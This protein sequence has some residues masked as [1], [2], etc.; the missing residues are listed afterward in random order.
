MRNSAAKQSLRNS[1]HC[2]ARKRIRKVHLI[3]CPVLWNSTAGL[4]STSTTSWG[5]RILKVFQEFKI[6]ENIGFFILDNASSN[7]TCVDLVLY[8]LYLEMSAKQHLRRRLRYLGHV[9]NLS[10][11]VFLLGQQSQETLGQLEL[12]YIQNNFD[13]IAKVWKKQGVL[14]RLHNIIRYIRMTP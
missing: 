12:A 8:K 2:V 11:Q 13:G 6:R 5:A 14:G 7:N 4:S 3:L 9:I 1:W 10:A